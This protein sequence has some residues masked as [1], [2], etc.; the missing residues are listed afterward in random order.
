VLLAEVL[1]SRFYSSLAAWFAAQLSARLTAWRG[2]L[3]RAL[4]SV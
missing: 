2:N 3:I 1:D 4:I